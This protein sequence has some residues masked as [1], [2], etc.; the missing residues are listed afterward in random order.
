M[1]TVDNVVDDEKAVDDTFTVEDV[2]AAFSGA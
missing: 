1:V 2:C